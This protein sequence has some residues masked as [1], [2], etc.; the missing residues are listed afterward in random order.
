M[1]KEINMISDEFKNINSEKVIFGKKEVL[2]ALKFGKVK[3]IVFSSDIPE[4]LLEEIK[5][6]T[7]S[8]EV[9]VNKFDGHNKELGMICKR[10]HGILMI[11]LLK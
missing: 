4:K 6:L 8:F 3:S 2:R 11:A 10:P 7:E 9:E 1:I 5:E